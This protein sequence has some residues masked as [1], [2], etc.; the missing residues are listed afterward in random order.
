MPRI[1]VEGQAVDV[2]PVI[3]GS[4]LLALPAVKKLAGQDRS[5][6]MVSPDGQDM[7]L[8]DPEKQCRPQDG[9]QI[10]AVARSES[11]R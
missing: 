6:F 3:A 11:G 5:V 10:D 7:Q 8:I 4:E 2:P 9:T 1:M